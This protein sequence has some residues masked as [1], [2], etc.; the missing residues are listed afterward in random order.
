MGHD[1]Q[2]IQRVRLPRILTQHL[3]IQRLGL[4]QS[5]GLVMLKRQLESGSQG[6]HIVSQTVRSSNGSEAAESILKLNTG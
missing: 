3:T 6:G 1:T 2:E 5:A 4:R